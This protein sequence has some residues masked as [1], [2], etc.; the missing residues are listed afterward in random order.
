[1]IQAMKVNLGAAGGVQRHQE[2]EVQA[3]NKK[4]LM[5]QINVI[6]KCMI[7]GRGYADNDF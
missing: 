6:N 4:E 2:D 5:I 7:R 3:K 1:M